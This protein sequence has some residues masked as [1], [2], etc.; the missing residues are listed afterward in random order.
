LK[1]SVLIT[2][3]N[4]EKYIR[5]TLDSVL[6]QKTNFSHEVLVGD[7]GSTD[8]TIEIIKEYQSR[9]PEKIKL[10]VMPRES[11]KEY[12][13]VE[14]SA[15]NRLNLLEKATGEYCCFLDGDDYYL[16]ETKLQR[17]VDVLEKEENQDC[18]MCAH[19]LFLTYET[20]E[21]VLLCKAKKERKITLQ[22]YWPLMFLQ[23]NAILFR[24]IY[25]Q[26]QPTGILAKSFDDNNITFWLFQHGKMYY[27][28]QPMGAYRQVS[29][30]SWNA[31]DEIQKASSNV[32]G[33]SVELSVSKEHRNLSVI[34]HYPDFR[35]LYENRTKISKE[36]CMPFYQTAK[37]NH[38]Q[39]ALWFYEFDE[40]DAAMEKKFESLLR[41][42]KRG[43]FIAKCKRAFLKVF[44]LY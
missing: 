36:A 30:S 29:G 35:S 42:A 7:D 40:E 33:Y 44:R 31:I 8:G 3:Y 24:N 5:Q 20:G 28:P 11:G 25:R 32:L 14:R 38:V 41:R 34:R 15:A 22:Q 43:Y 2:T 39:E 23:A 12:N 1:V 10:F 9:Y 13:R 4:L 17:Q 19:N 21:K 6:M 18:V 16:D 37:E 26:N 27:L